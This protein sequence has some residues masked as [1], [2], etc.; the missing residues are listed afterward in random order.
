M[1]QATSDYPN[2]RLFI[3]MD[4]DAVVDQ[5]FRNYSLN[6]IIG[7][8]Q[9]KMHWEPSEKPLVFNQDGPSWWCKLVRDVGYTMC[10]NAGTVV[11]YRHPVSLQLLESWW[12]ASMEPYAGNPLKRSLHLISLKQ[13][14]SSDLSSH[15]FTLIVSLS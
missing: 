8:A 15:F 9:K 5:I 4:S 3:Y 14:I 11:W 13:A 6:D 7:Y 1:I 10:L 2:I 12:H